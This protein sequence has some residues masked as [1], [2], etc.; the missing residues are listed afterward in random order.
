MFDRILSLGRARSLARRLAEDPSP[1][2]YLALA[3]SHVA[4]GRLADVV[5]VCDEALALHPGHAELE[6][7]RERALALSR[8]DRIRELQ[9]QI[10]QSPRPALFRE[11]CETLVGAGRLARAEKVVGE[12]LEACE[13]DEAL[14]QLGVVRAE[15]YFADRRREDARVALERFEDFARRR[16]SDLRPLRA[17]LDIQSRC[18][19]WAEAR[20]TLARLLE[21]AP[22]DPALEARFRTVAALS[23][24]ARS[25]D[26]A[27]REVERSGRFVDDEVDAERADSTQALRPALQAAAGIDGVRGAFYVRGGT[28]LVQGPRGASA[29]RYARGVREVVGATR[30]AARRLGLGHIHEVLLEGDFGALVVRPDALGAAALWVEGEPGPRSDEA[31]TMLT[32]GAS[33]PEGDAA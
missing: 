23:A 10:R 5:R 26:Q 28:A 19:A 15:R 24:G 11:L 22:G 27:L 1:R 2:N 13:D 8:E 21:L 9:R 29:E 31:L 12:W 33:P 20:R 6:R 32:G 30:S 3:Q 25:L 16:P 7:T 14:F 17:Q 18:G 4:A